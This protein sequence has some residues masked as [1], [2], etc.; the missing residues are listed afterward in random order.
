MK[1]YLP[2]SEKFAVKHGDI[3]IGESGIPFMI[4]RGSQE[5]L[6]V[7]NLQSGTIVRWFDHACDLPDWIH[8]YK[9]KHYPQGIYRY[10]LH[11]NK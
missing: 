7:V 9:Y 5:R 11:I 4:I 10:Q 6:R 1:V 2:E 3:L 8:K